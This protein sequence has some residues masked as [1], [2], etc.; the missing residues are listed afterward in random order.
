MCATGFQLRDVGASLSWEALSA[1]LLHLSP[2]SATAAE[3]R[4]ALSE[5]S[6]RLKTNVL[7]ADLYDLGQNINANLVAMIEHRKAK[8]FRPYPRPWAKKDGEKHFGRGALPTTELHEWI[9]EKRRAHGR[10]IH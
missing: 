6:T 5:W 1:F 9:E 10:R 8:K 4:P 3:L 7:L 2:E